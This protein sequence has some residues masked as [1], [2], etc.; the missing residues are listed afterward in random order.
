MEPVVSEIK[1]SLMRPVCTGWDRGFL[2]S[3]L[4]Q[5][6][7]GRTLS[8]K[9]MSTLNQV[10]ERNSSDAQKEHEVWTEVYVAEHQS[11]AVV[12]A[13]YYKSTGYFQQLAQ[14][15]L[16]GEI[17]EHISYMKMRN[18]KY[19]RKV[20]DVLK[21]EAKYDVGAYVVPR[22]SCTKGRIRFDDSNNFTVPWVHADSVFKS[23][24]DKGGFVLALHDTIY[25]AANGAKT[26]KIL[27][28]GATIPFIVEERF[29]K[30]KR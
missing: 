28:I 23:F 5:I 19:A 26:Y 22:A 1:N 9:Q 8:T 21:S 16:S 24:R 7:R 12:L 27:P 3:V 13:R 4:E 20:L 11:D 25:S 30:T 29:I 18:N 10:L 15:I 2:E 14:A 17:P 6:D